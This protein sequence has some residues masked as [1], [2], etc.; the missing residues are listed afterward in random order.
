[1]IYL[2]VIRLKHVKLLI[3]K[4][5][6]NKELLF[7]RDFREV[8][9]MV[10]FG[11]N[12]WLKFNFFIATICR[13]HEKETDPYSGSVVL[14]NINSLKKCQSILKA[15]QIQNLKYSDVKLPVNTDS[16]MG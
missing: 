5:F 14:F 3:I 10:Y 2:N 8:I 11:W 4:I 15:R 13:R 7:T 12:W 9:E 16:A 1:M 6:S